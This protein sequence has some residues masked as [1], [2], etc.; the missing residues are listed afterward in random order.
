MAKKQWNVEQKQSPAAIDNEFLLFMYR[1]LFMH[2][3]I[4]E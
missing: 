4:D 3:Y 1:I 2:K